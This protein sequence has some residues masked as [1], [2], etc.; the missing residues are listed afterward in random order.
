MMASPPALVLPPADDDSADASNA[1]S[2]TDTSLIGGAGGVGQPTRGKNHS[3]DAKKVGFTPKQKLLIEWAAH[4]RSTRELI[5]GDGID[6]GNTCQS[7]IIMAALAAFGVRRTD[8][9][10]GFEQSSDVQHNRFERLRA[11]LQQPGARG[12]AARSGRAL[13]LAAT[14]GGHS[15]GRSRGPVGCGAWAS[16]ETALL[17][18]QQQRERRQQQVE[19]RSPAAI[20]AAAAVA[21]MKAAE[22][23]AAEAESQ[24]RQLQADTAADRAEL[25]DHRAAPN[26]REV[27]AALHATERALTAEQAKTQTL[28]GARI[29][30]GMELAK[31]RSHLAAQEKQEERLAGSPRQLQ[32]EAMAAKAAEAEARRKLAECREMM[33]EM[34]RARSAAE[35][36]LQ[37]AQRAASPTSTIDGACLGRGARECP[38]RE[39]GTDTTPAAG[40]G[41]RVRPLHKG[42]N[43]PYDPSI[44][45]LIRRF[46]S[47]TKISLSNV[48]PALA[49]AF[50]IHTGEVPAET[51]MVQKALVDGA[52][53]KLSMLDQENSAEAAKLRKHG[54]AIAGDTGNRKHCAQYKGAMEVMVQSY[55][56]EGVGPT[57]KPLACTDLG[58]DQTA[59]QGH[60]AYK[61][62]FDRAGLTAKMLLQV[63]TDNTEHAQ[64]G[65]RKFVEAVLLADPTT[66]KGRAIVENCYRH[67]TVL[68]EQAAMAAAFAGDEIVNYL[69]MFY[70]VWHA[71]PEYYQAIWEQCD[72]PP[73]VFDALMRMPDPT[74]RRSIPCPPLLSAPCLLRSHT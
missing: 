23:R 52:F 2:P 58:N 11:E 40:L 50:T 55:W 60:L 44:C 24:L 47:E 36:S 66:K 30:A 5:F 56:E 62:A 13:F 33:K 28:E 72:L 68:E 54:V 53:D 74:V 70:E 69:R 41:V 18:A 37:Q 8:D 12:T 39:M 3:P 43:T 67:L 19:A 26:D 27:R 49:L 9:G 16:G 14:R 10:T 42:P 51:N 15:R 38:G 7:A 1:R 73:D 25:A 21:A 20:K 4:N 46:V 35:A 34:Q 64:L 59:Q 32:L 57:A 45:E 17:L 48:A 65:M 61:A 22:A 6:R 63:E 29:A 31:L 71:Q